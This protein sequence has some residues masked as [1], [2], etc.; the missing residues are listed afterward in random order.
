MSK[1]IVLT[2]GGSAGHVTPNLAI[3]PKLEKMGFNIEYIGTKKGI[4]RDIITRA[5]FPYHIISAGKL[6]RYFSFK[7]FIDPV[8]IIA[9][10]LKSRKILKRLNPSAVF[11]KGGFVGVPVVYAAYG[12]SIPTVLHE[13]DSTPG[14]ANRLCIKRAQTVC[15]AF[16]SALRSIPEGKGVITGLPI[17]EKLLGGDRERGLALCGFSGKKPVLLIMGGSLGAKAL[18]DTVDAAMPGLTRKYDVAHIRGEKNMGD[19]CSPAGCKPFGY[20]DEEL[21]DIYAAAD[22]ML[23]RAGATAVFE[24][25]ALAL[26]ALLVPMP[27][28]ASRGDQLEN[29]EYFKEKGFSHVLPQERMTEES[30]IGAIDELYKD[31]EALSARMKRENTT[32]AAAAVAQIIADAKR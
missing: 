11:S 32:D 26:P 3:I 28:S 29:A 2:G 13:S 31:R 24:I 27:Q 6:R 20:V 18:N 15:V 9:G 8:K 14:L 4:E 7:N 25:L 12:L 22:I 5:G 17:R 1:T 21:A 23:S 30:L 19:C 10:Y 16:E